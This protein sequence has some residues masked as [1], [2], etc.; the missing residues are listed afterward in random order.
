MRRRPMQAW[1]LALGAGQLSVIRAVWVALSVVSS[2]DPTSSTE[3]QMLSLRASSFRRP[4]MQADR[5]MEGKN[6]P[7]IRKNIHLFFFY[8]FLSTIRGHVFDRVA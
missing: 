8:F 5:F 2:V 3:K 6:N 1:S 7:K 4:R